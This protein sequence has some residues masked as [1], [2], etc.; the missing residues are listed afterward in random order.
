MEHAAGVGRLASRTLT[1]RTLTGR[2]QGRR[3]T[4]CLAVYGAPQSRS[5]TGSPNDV[6]LVPR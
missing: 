5:W 4:F 3:S 6:F 1:G 2:S